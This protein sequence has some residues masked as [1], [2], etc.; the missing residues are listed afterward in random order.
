MYANLR[1]PKM[2][3]INGLK[4]NLNIKN[5]NIKPGEKTRPP[6]G[7]FCKPRTSNLNKIN[8]SGMFYIACMAIVWLPFPNSCFKG[9]SS[10]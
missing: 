10:V 9:T 2:G 8:I 5:M 3:N 6:P 1:Q 4:R 7:V